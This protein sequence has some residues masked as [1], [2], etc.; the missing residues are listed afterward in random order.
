MLVYQIRKSL[1]HNLFTYWNTIVSRAAYPKKVITQEP[2]IESAWE[3][4][5]HES[6]ISMLSRI[7]KISS[8]RQEFSVQHFLFCKLPLVTIY[9]SL[10]LLHDQKWSSKD[11]KYTHEEQSSK[12]NVTQS[13]FS[14]LKY[15]H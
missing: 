7:H 15:H 13:Q 9:D 3:H 2:D 6:R 4:I 12:K 1:H 5:V 10:Y 11:L 14:I 8:D